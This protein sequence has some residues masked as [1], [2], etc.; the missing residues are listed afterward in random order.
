MHEIDHIQAHIVNGKSYVSPPPIKIKIVAVS[1]FR[2]QHNALD[3]DLIGSME[4]DVAH[5]PCTRSLSSL[6]EMSSASIVGFFEKNMI[7]NRLLYE[8]FNFSRKTPLIPPGKPQPLYV[9]I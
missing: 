4:L 6:F 5:F 2:V 9:R 8:V 7:L 3:W 1:A